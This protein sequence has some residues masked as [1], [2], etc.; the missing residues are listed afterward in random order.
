MAS[1]YRPTEAIQHLRPYLRLSYP[2]ASTRVK[3]FSSSRPANATQSSTNNSGPNPGT[4]PVTHRKVTV[5]NDDGRVRWSEL[6]V[7]EK[8][9]RTT[10]QSFNLAIVAVGVLATGAVGY[11]LFSDVFSPDSKTA[12]FNRATDRIRRDRKCQELLGD[13]SKISAHGEASW[14]RWARNRYISSTVETDKWGTEHLKFRFFV[15]GPLGQ[16]VVHVHMAK[17]PSQ[18]EYEYVML[19][20][21]VKGHQRVY[22]ENADDRKNSKVAPKIFGARWW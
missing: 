22:L 17:R 4:G 13:G 19:A 9:A 7:G 21:D 5:V 1:L 14:S 12:H 11:M 2:H 6:S 10:Q 16:G 3:A 20:V 8:A 15:E 18:S